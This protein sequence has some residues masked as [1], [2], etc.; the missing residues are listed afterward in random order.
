[1]PRKLFKPGQS[2]NPKGRPRGTKNKTPVELV[3]EIM[4]IAGKLKD[5]DKGLLDCAKQNPKWFY[6]NFLKPI[7]PKNVDINFED[8]PPLIFN[9]DFGEGKKDKT[10]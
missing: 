6:E 2:G 1:M 10:D 5:E 9:M 4:E 3:K 8:L 7:I